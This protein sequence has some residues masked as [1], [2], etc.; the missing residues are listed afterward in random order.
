MAYKEEGSNKMIESLKVDATQSFL[1]G[2]EIALEQA[3]IVLPV[4]MDGFKLEG[5]GV[6]CLISRNN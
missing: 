2:F 6:N 1:V 5:R 4:R 3:T